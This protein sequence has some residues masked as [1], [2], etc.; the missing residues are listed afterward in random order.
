MIGPHAAINRI[1]AT[2]RQAWHGRQG[3]DGGS[4]PS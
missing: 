3:F 1:V 4:L 2:P